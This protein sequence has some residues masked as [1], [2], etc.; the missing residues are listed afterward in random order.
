MKPRWSRL[1]PWIAILLTA[2]IGAATI[3]LTAALQPGTAAVAG[4]PQGGV[5]SVAGA[6]QGPQ[7]C[8]ECHPSEFYSWAGTTHANASFDPIFQAYLQSVDQQGECFACHTTGYDAQTGQF[9]TAGVTCE[10]CHGPYRDDHPGQSMEIAT[11]D[12]LCG[13]CHRST[14]AEWRTSNHGQAGIACVACHEVHSQKTHMQTDSDALCAGCHE[15]DAQDD[16]HQTHHAAAIGCIRCHVA[17]PEFDAG[18]AVSGMA[19]TGHSFAAAPGICADCH[20]D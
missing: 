2:L 14:V 9:V 18:A 15:R 16:L 11:A 4:N 8:A 3:L 12:D 6:Y 19:E 13:T 5:S 20:P 17:R 1:S 10:S 7:H